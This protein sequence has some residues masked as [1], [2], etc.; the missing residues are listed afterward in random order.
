[1]DSWPEFLLMLSLLA[2]ALQANLRWANTS[3]FSVLG[4]ALRDGRF[5]AAHDRRGTPPV[6]LVSETLARRLG[7]SPLGR[8]LVIATEPPVEVS[9]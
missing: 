3:A 2:D 9:R 1:M 6:A 5:F 8:T 7:G 4:I